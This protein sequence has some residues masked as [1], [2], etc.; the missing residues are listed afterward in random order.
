MPKE[1]KVISFRFRD[2]DFFDFEVNSKI[3]ERL[4]QLFA[5]AKIAEFRGL[6]LQVK[7]GKSLSKVKNKVGK[8]W[9]K[10]EIKVGKSYEIVPNFNNL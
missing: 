6:K 10:F 8:I 3:I 7:L 5:E 4:R 9:S 2:L 1:F